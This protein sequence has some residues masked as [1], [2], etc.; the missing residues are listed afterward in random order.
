MSLVKEIA[1]AHE[2]VNQCT[3][4]CDPCSF[5]VFQKETNKCDWHLTVR[6][7]LVKS[8]QACRCFCIQWHHNQLWL[9][10]EFKELLFRNIWFHNHIAAEAILVLFPLIFRY[11]TVESDFR[12]Y[13]CN[14]NQ[15]IPIASIPSTTKHC[16][17]IHIAFI[18]KAVPAVINIIEQDILLMKSQH[19]IQVFTVFPGGYCCLDIFRLQRRFIQEFC[20]LV[21][22]CI[23]ILKQDIHGDNLSPFGLYLAQPPAQNRHEIVPEDDCVTICRLLDDFFTDRQHFF[24]G[25]TFLFRINMLNYGCFILL[26]KCHIL[27][28]CRIIK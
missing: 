22:C 21:F 28:I 15:E 26:Q 13:F 1:D 10:H 2:V 6:S 19:L 4:K 25:V 24:R 7:S 16:V 14:L 23:L 3:A 11:N 12:H 5:F 17:R 8:N 9:A 18:I 27:L 20:Q